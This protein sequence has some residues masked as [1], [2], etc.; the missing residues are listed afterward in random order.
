L[1]LRVPF[2]IEPAV[3]VHLGPLWLALTGIMGPVWVTGS[4]PGINVGGRVSLGWEGQAH[5]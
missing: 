4:I 2:N 5:P 1:A 3:G